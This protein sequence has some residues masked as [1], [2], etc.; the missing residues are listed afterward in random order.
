[1]LSY[2]IYSLV[3]SQPPIA[4]RFNTIQVAYERFTKK[5]QKNDNPT[6]EEVQEI[7]DCLK[8]DVDQNSIF[9]VFT[10]EEQEMINKIRLEEYNSQYSAFKEILTNFDFEQKLHLYY[11]TWLSRRTICH[12]LFMLSATS[13]TWVAA[14]RINSKITNKTYRNYDNAYTNFKIKTMKAL[15]GGISWIIK[16]I[17]PAETSDF[18]EKT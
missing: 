15:V 3:K 18:S 11:N 4:Q 6:K 14:K 10:T 16:I 8:N 1:M 5:P 17:D 13:L 7:L 12:L 9:E 2:P